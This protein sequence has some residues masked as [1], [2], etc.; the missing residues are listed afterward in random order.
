MVK[1]I[2]F[3]KK[4][5]D[6]V[7]KAQTILGCCT[8]ILFICM[9]AYQ[10]ISRIT[11]TKA[12]FTEEISTTSFIWT[13]FMGSAVELRKYEHYRFTGI[14]EKLKGKAFWINEFII[15]IL[16]T[17]FSVLMTVHGFHLVIM[18]RS[19]SFS[20]MMGVSRDWLWAVM[21]TFGITCTMYQ[22]ESLLKFL[23]D[24]STKKTVNVADQLLA[25]SEE[26]SKEENAK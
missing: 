25:E 24:P 23:H 6:I 10:V 16:I 7:E 8:L 11:G 14:A 17:A 4:L 19:W 26:I 22:I 12:F 3:F 13:A 15:I 21:P 2:N 18:F 1:A 20:S 9:V 5:N